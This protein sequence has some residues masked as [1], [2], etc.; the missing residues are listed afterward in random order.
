MKEQ[1]KSLKLNLK[2]IAKQIK[3]Q[4]KVRKK[5]HPHHDK[6]L[7]DYALLC[8][9]EEFRHKHVAY[10]IVRGRDLECID[11]GKGLNMDRVNWI[12]KTMQPESKEKLYV[13]VNENLSPS[14]QAVQSAHAVAAFT[15]KFPYTMWRNGYLVLL[16]DKPNYGGDMYG[17][18][19]GHCEYANFREP[20]L[21]NKVT[22]YAVFGEAAERAMK[23]KV[24]L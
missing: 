15:Q 21:G 20:D 9:R 16:K 5:S 18:V 24:L 19:S 13:V 6:Y 12:I 10:C 7:G 14:Q 1:I 11:S 8:L 22:A 17:F 23:Q 2:E 3:N 4:K